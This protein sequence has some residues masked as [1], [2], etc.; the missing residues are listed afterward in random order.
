MKTSCRL[1]KELSSLPACKPLP[2]PKIRQQWLWAAGDRA[3]AARKQNQKARTHFCLGS[4]LPKATMAVN[5][6]AT[7]QKEESQG[8]DSWSMVTLDPFFPPK[9]SF[10][11]VAAKLSNHFFLCDE[12]SSQKKTLLSSLILREV[13]KFEPMLSGSWFWKEPCLVLVFIYLLVWEKWCNHF[14]KMFF[15]FSLNALNGFWVNSLVP[16]NMI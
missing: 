13:L 16:L 3:E 15:S 2:N 4:R 7:E 5:K 1:R 11:W 9:K 12:N 8:E 14:N 6:A 10:E